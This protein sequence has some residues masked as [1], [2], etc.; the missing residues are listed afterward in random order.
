MM[1]QVSLGSPLIQTAPRTRRRAVSEWQRRAVEGLVS[2]LAFAVWGKLAYTGV[3]RLLA[4]WQDMPIG[5]HWTLDVLSLM[6]GVS[7]SIAGMSAIWAII[8]RSLG[9]TPSSLIGAP[10][11]APAES[12]YHDHDR[13][14][15]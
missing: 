3:F 2:V 9:R 12:L 15:D 10:D 8:M 7:G 4:R 14:H 6:I 5:G 13:D 11:D 1:G